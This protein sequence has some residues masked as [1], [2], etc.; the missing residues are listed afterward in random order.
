MSATENTMGLPF[1]TLFRPLSHRTDRSDLAYHVVAWIAGGIGM[2]VPVA[3]FAY[4]LW[5]GIGVINWDFLFSPP[6]GGSLDG[7]GGIWPAIAGS[8]ALVGY[9]LIP[10]LFLGI[11][12]GIY[13][14]E[15]NRSP[16]LEH[17]ARFCIESLSA[18]PG[19]VYSLFGYAMLVV[20]LQLKTSLVAGAVTLGFVM[21]PQILIGTHEALKAVDPVLRET[22]HALG[23]SHSYLFFRVIWPVAWPAILTSVV[24]SA[25]HALGA[26]APLLFTAATVFTKETVALSKPVMAL[27]THLYF[28][29]AEIG[30]VPYAFGTA[31]VLAGL[32][33]SVSVIALIFKRRHVH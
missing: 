22:A 2:L 1:P 20:A 23:V 9:G 29:T 10:A 8:L 12:G 5:H 6:T 27:P 32:V 24:L 14:A 4:L 17:G 26:A 31:L 16:T 18:V 25:I 7:Q 3:I 28:V 11:G 21:L 15:F 13:L 30:A 33:L 19:L